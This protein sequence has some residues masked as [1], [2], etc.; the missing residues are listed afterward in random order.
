MILI[1]PLLQ[2]NAERSHQFHVVIFFIFLVSNIGGALSPLG[3][4]PLF[5]GFLHGVD[6]FWPLRSLWPAVC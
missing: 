5:F 4:P 2:A 6:F 1:R 3:N